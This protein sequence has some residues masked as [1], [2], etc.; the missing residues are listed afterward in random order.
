MHYHLLAADT[1]FYSNNL[2]IGM[3]NNK[4]WDYQ[5]ATQLVAA[6]AN[7]T[8]SSA[9]LVEETIARIELFDKKINAVVVRDF[10][11]A[12]LAAKAADFAI[13][14]GQRLPLLGLPMTVKESF[15]VTGLPTSWGN[16]EYK[17]WC[18]EEDALA[19][20]RLKAAGAII[21]G[22]TNVPSMLM[23]W[24]SYNNIYGTTN[25]PWNT[26]LTPGGSSG[27]SAAALAA[28]FV[29]LELGSDFA[30]SVR[31]PAHYCGIFSHKPSANLVP[32]RGAGPPTS[33]PSPHLLNDFVVAGPMAR[34]AADLSLA[35]GILAGP[36]EM[37]DG[38]G[39]RLS[40]P[41]ARQDQ[42]RN[43][44]VL[45]INTH[46]L[47][48]TAIAITNAID[49]LSERLAQLGVKVSCETHRLPNLAEIARTYVTL[50]AA[51]LQF[52]TAEKMLPTDDMSLRACFL[53]G[54][55]LSYRDWLMKMRVRGALRQ[56]W[57]NLFKEFDV[58]IC[59][60]TPTPA[61]PHDHSA[62]ENRT[63]EVDG[64]LFPYSD[65]YAWISIA[66]LFGLPATVVPIGHTEKG[67]PIG[68]QVIGDYLED[69]TT[70][71]FA[72]LLEREFGGFSIPPD[73]IYI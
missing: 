65:Q 22:K 61:F 9:E 59:P 20:S 39:Y 29:S 41:P 33:P 2:V 16:L 21:I 14:K 24:Q 19:V 67:L 51:F 37:W 72:A 28:G 26:S 45:I 60:V 73:F 6:L 69:H 11:R 1:L 12:R 62:P 13:A 66:T 64:L 5:S 55:R 23:D 50:F 25:N 27:G 34:T 10:A 70:L 47:C 7:K 8:I 4:N 52:E 49:H 46:P 18:P 38:K 3:K 32:M 63:I 71:Q 57:R 30:G 56:Q 58:V 68:I 31:I 17:N 42:I 53:R 43:F 15:N 48:S 35:L 44:R 36:D 40:L 54:C